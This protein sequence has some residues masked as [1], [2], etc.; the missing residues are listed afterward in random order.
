MKTS[1]DEKFKGFNK[2]LAESK[3]KRVKKVIIHHP[4]VLGDDY[5][6]IVENL[7]RLSDAELEL[8]IVPRSQRSGTAKT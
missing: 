6:E 8:C 3:K 5:D 2:L 1:H 4:E 7:N